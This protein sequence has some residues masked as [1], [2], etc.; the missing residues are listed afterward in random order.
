MSFALIRAATSSLRRP[1]RAF[2]I[3]VSGIDASGKT[4][5]SDGL[6]SFLARDWHVE[7]I[8]L[9]DF[10]NAKQYRYAGRS[11]VE[12]YL[13]K[14]FNFER[15]EQQILDP[16][17]SS[18]E[19]K[20]SDAVLDLEKDD[21]SRNLELCVRKESIV[22]VEGVFLFRAEWRRYFDLT[23]F[24]S[25]QEV[26]AASRGITRDSALVPDAARRFQEK[27]LPAQRIFAQR[28]RP[29]DAADLVIDNS[30]FRNPAVLVDRVSPRLIA[31]AK[32]S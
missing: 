1:D 4:L 32:C 25:V 9:D 21:F 22:I 10:H 6:K 5:F 20:F 23:I 18:G 29:E 30:D 31:Q 28:N 3:G 11:E 17:R 26:V 12:N 14:S 16:I 2:V 8:H 19:L 24:L 13:T 27:Y 15:F 7:L